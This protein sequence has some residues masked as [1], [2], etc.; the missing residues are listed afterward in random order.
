LAADQLIP[1]LQF[2][3]RDKSFLSGYIERMFCG[4]LDGLAR[5]CARAG[6]GRGVEQESDSG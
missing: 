3:R 1:H 6:E 5:R 4:G 2:T